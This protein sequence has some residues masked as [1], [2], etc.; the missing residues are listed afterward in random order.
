MPRLPRLGAFVFV[1]LAAP[2]ASAQ[3]AHLVRDI[4][5]GGAFSSS[6]PTSLTA[7]GDTVFF[8]ADDGVHGSELW[9]SDG[10]ADGTVLVKDINPDWGGV[11]GSSTATLAA[12]GGKVYFQA[13]DR[14]H[15]LELW[16]S[17]G[18][19]DGTVL[20]KDIGL[21]PYSSYPADLTVL[22]GVLYFTA[23]VDGSL[24]E[25]WKTD[26]TERGTVRVAPWTTV[27]ILGPLTGLNRTLFFEGEGYSLAATGSYV[28]LGRA[29]WKSDGTAA[30]TVLVSDVRDPA[31]ITALDGRLLFSADDGTHGREL[32]R[33]DGT[34]AG[35]V[36]VRDIA[37]GD[38]SPGPITR[39]NRVAF[40]G[41][42][43]G[44]EPPGAGPDLWKSDGTEAGTTP[45][46]DFTPYFE[47]DDLALGDFT[48]VDGTLFF[49]LADG[50]GQPLFPGRPG[51][52]V[53][54]SDG[55]ADGTVFVKASLPEKKTSPTYAGRPG[56]FTNVNGLLFFDAAD[57]EAGNELWMSDGTAEGTVQVQDIWP[58]AGDSN[59]TGVTRVGRRLFFAANDGL[60]GS[61]L[62]V[63][64]LDVLRVARSGGGSGVVTSL[65]PGIA[66]G[67][68][69]SEAFGY[70]ATVTL[71]A[72]PDPGSTFSGWFGGACRGKGE[73]ALNVNGAQTVT[74]R[75]TRED[76]GRTDFD[77]DGQGDLLWQHQ[78]TGE[79]YAWLLDGTIAADAT[80]LGPALLAGWQV[81]GVAD[82]D[83]DGDVDVLWQSDTT[84]ELYVWFLDGRSVARGGYLTPSRC[85]DA[86]WQIR[87]VGDFD[88]NGSPDLLWHN[89]ATGDV[90][91]WLM[92]GTS[93][94]SGRVVGPGRVDPRWRLSLASDLN[95]D[96]RSD[97]LWHNRESGELYVW[98]LDG[99]TVAS[100]GYLSPSRFKDPR[101]W[102]VPR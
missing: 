98:Y 81:R 102:I 56:V 42:R 2:F 20:L 37:A 75:F 27:S 70:G 101:W 76:H 44:T 91:T 74:A 94:A 36:L 4:L 28:P 86:L 18:T 47:S 48:D 93:A 7:I 87:G 54:K 73:C 25:L 95:D 99:T 34:Q 10:S 79:L 55:T 23:T 41:A 17:D 50:P 80:R 58:G 85:G 21:G 31:E 72:T 29:L 3:P 14:I 88:G 24:R 35:T 69:C 92:K 71:T 78:D 68:D 12:F 82:F 53:W 97:L 67:T 19:A 57:A 9:T 8:A 59:P 32:W 61:E 52:E 15:G 89:Q 26:G 6:R 66:C 43:D 22:G 45:V 33:S 13:D 40:F 60:T 83:V 30:G 65:T 5:P 46:K 84:G 62:W 1:A 38:A 96:G 90:Y 64:D 11:G 100:A 49:T 51:Y 77:A 63:L 39:S 16:R